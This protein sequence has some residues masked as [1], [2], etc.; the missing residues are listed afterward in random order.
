M[1]SSRRSRNCSLRR[2]LPAAD[3]VAALAAELSE[4]TGDPIEL[5]RPSDPTHGDYAT[6]A[7]LQLAAARRRPPRELAEELAAAASALPA[8]ER[9]EVAGPGFVNLWLTDA[10]L[11]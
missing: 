7:A 1:R 9:T 10:W 5:D 3:P 6:N 8:V 11:S 2:P 4:A